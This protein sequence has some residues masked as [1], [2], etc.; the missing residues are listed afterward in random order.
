M[1]QVKE[2]MEEFL[3][4]NK[5]LTKSEIIHN[6]MKFKVK[7]KHLYHPKIRATARCLKKVTNQT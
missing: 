2:I 7:I 1:V 4:A 5:L 3:K 6:P